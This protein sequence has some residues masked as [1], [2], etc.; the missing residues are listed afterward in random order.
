[1][2]WL[3]QNS[4]SGPRSEGSRARR[5]D[6]GSQGALE[7]AAGAPLPFFDRG[8]RSNPRARSRASTTGGA[9]VPSMVGG[10]PPHGG[11]KAVLVNQE[12]VV[13]SPGFQEG[14]EPGMVFC[15]RR[16]RRNRRRG[17]AGKPPRVRRATF[18]PQPRRI[19]A[20]TLRVT[21]GF[22]SLGPLAQSLNASYAVPVGRFA[23]SFLQTPPGDD[24]LAVRL[25]V[26]VTRV[27]RGLPP[28]SRRSVNHLQSTRAL[29]Q[30]RLAWHTEKKARV[31]FP[32]GPRG[33]GRLGKLAS[34]T[35]SGNFSTS[36]FNCSAAEPVRGAA[37]EPDQAERTSARNL[38]ISSL[39]RVA[40][41]DS[42]WVD[43]ST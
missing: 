20:Q 43:E 18:I 34:P 31:G 21:S 4:G 37:S 15:A 39:I 2:C 29:A 38:S 7:C 5:W 32:R 42:S 28:P 23:Y 27:R 41:C 26:P 3:A 8:P 11:V 1:M 30:T 6:I 17:Q 13:I 35:L 12:H 25:T 36:P 16:C 33:Y 19:Y 14:L 40:C 10:D 22:G 9:V 24:A